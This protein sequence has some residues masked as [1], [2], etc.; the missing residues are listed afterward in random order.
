LLRGLTGWEHPRLLLG[1]FPETLEELAEQAPDRLSHVNRYGR[2]G[3][4]ALSYGN[5]RTGHIADA[6][7]MLKAFAATAGQPQDEAVVIRNRLEK[8]AF[9][10]CQLV[11]IRYFHVTRLDGELFAMYDFA[12]PCRTTWLGQGNTAEGRVD[13]SLSAPACGHDTDCCIRRDSSAPLNEQARDTA[14]SLRTRASL[15]PGFP[16]LQYTRAIACDKPAF[17]GCADWCFELR[18]QWPMV[19][20]PTVYLT[21]WSYGTGLQL[22][23]NVTVH[24]TVT[25]RRLPRS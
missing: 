9:V 12:F 4:D 22:S 20:D 3:A 19:F 8:N 21:S 5:L 11:Q 7:P 24:V 10:E 1:H 6:F 13:R 14:V 23:G 15:F 18:A 25:G 16:A 2:G 17:L